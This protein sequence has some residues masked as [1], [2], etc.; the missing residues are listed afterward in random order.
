MQTIGMIL[1]AC[2]LS[3]GVASA[4]Q[5]SHGIDTGFHD[6]MEGAAAGPFNDAD[7]ARF[8]AQAT[9]GPTAA[10]IAYLRALGYEGWLDLQFAAPASTQVQY[11]NWVQSLPVDND[12]TDAT[13]LQIWTINAVGT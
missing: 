8:L 12:V 4:Q 10:D 11:L 7:A 3:V 1:A 6:G 13:R 2:V 9:F 5:P